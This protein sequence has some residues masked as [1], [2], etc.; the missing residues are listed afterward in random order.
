MKKTWIFIERF[1]MIRTIFNL[2]F[3]NILFGFTQ[4]LII[5]SLN[6][7]GGLEEVGLYTLALG[8]VAPITVLLNMG[9][10]VHYNTNKNDDDFINYQIIRIISS[11]LIII[12]SILICLILKYEFSTSFVIFL[13]ASLKS[14]ESILEL[15]YGFLQ[16]KELH[17]LI[18][19]SKNI[20][21]ICLII[22]IATCY[23][24]L[25]GNLLILLIG[26][27]IFNIIFYFLYDFNYIKK[28]KESN[29]I[30]ISII[31]KIVIT[32]LPLAVATTFDTLN[33]NIQRIILNYYL[34]IEK[35]GIYASLTTIMVT[36]QLV[37]S[38]IMT[39][40]LPKLN[41]FIIDGKR[42]KL[43]KVLIY[44]VSI[45]FLIGLSLIGSIAFFGEWILP[46]IFTNHYIP[47]KNLAV[48]IMIVGMF[49]Y[50]AGVLN[51]A[52]VAFNEFNRQMFAVI[53]SFLTMLIITTL[54]VNDFGIYGAA[55]AL[56]IGMIVRIISFTIILVKKIR[57]MKT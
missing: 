3:S 9:L 20:R 17:N 54:S 12:I 15:D 40:F 32:S 24:I 47:Y 34:G 21:S 42:K 23:L 57:R 49:W 41:Y 30:T 55:Y 33:I 4:F 35:V 52:V 45:A 10:K 25:N 31:I 39:Y 18:A 53:I 50:I 6:K 56:I 8:I 27:I 46:V 37:I 29:K 43:Q 7:F 51:L 14:I 48:L 26:L 11:V 28:V 19:K 1:S 38:S 16:K 36:G 22:W 2:L 44:L 5:V 13:V